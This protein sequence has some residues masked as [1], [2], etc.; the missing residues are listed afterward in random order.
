MA[1]FKFAYYG[2]TQSGSKE[3]GMEQIEK[4]KIWIESLGDKVVNLG[5]PFIGTKVLTEKDVKDKNEPNSMEG[6]AIAKVYN[7]GAAVEIG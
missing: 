2:G 4:F 1:N 7:M 3:E 6:F 5:T